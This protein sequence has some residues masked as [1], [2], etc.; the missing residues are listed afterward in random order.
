MRRNSIAELIESYFVHCTRMP[1]EEVGNIMEV[2]NPRDAK[3]RLGFEIVKIYHGEEAAREAQE[4]FV[5]TFSRREVPSDIREVTLSQEMSL[6][7]FLAQEG[8]AT[9]RGDARRK[10]EQGGV[11]VDGTKVLDRD[12]VLTN[13]G[14]SSIVKCGKKDFARVV[15]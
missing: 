15:F 3:I 11:E 6:L 7:D 9:S 5:S 4:Y 2:G 14:K 10:I 12:F 8:F 1:M 13:N